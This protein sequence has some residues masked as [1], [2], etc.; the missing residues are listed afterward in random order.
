MN[1]SSM[2]G[3]SDGGGFGGSGQNNSGGFG[4]GGRNSGA[5]GDYADSLRNKP[6]T[7]TNTAA[8][9]NLQLQLNKA[10]IDGDIDK[11]K[12]LQAEIAHLGQGGSG[13]GGGFLGGAL[14]SGKDPAT[15]DGYYSLKDK[16]Y[17]EKT[18]AAVTRGQ[19]QDWEKRFLP[20]Q[21]ELMG[22]AKDEILARQQL[23][24][25]DDLVGN[26]LRQAQ[27]GQDN[28]LGRMGVT[29]QQ[30]ANDNSQGLKQALMIAGTRNATRSHEKDRQM[31]ILTGAD[32]GTREK[33]QEGGL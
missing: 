23:A 13:G 2:G 14:G 24:R 19:Y 7:N 26:S 5:G 6:Q 12:Q 25:T 3:G 30:N 27:L 8:Q 4:A 31:G 16:H 10:L 18:F 21:R 15:H 33:L 28:Q 20:K 29:R 22:L 17:A 9:S 11:A 1:S 32:A